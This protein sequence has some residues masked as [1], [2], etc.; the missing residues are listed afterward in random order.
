M[1]DADQVAE[2]HF[3]NVLKV[4]DQVKISAVQN[5]GPLSETASDE[6]KRDHEIHKAVL[7]ALQAVQEADITANE[8]K[9]VEVMMNR[10]K[11]LALDEPGTFSF[12]AAWQMVLEAM[13]RS[14]GPDYHDLS[15]ASQFSIPNPTLKIL[16][17]SANFEDAEF[18]ESLDAKW[19]VFVV[20]SEAKDFQVFPPF[21]KGKPS[22]E[23]GLEN[24]H[25]LVSCGLL[26]LHSFAV[27][28]LPR[29]RIFLRTKQVLKVLSE[30]PL[31]TAINIPETDD[32]VFEPARNDYK[33]VRNVL[34][35]IKV[36]D[37]ASVCEKYPSTNSFISEYLQMKVAA[38]NKLH[39][40]IS[41]EYLWKVIVWPIWIL[42]PNRGHLQRYPRT[43]PF[44]GLPNWEILTK[45]QLELP[46]NYGEKQY[47]YLV[48]LC[49]AKEEVKETLDYV[50]PLSMQPAKLNLISSVWIDARANRVEIFADRKLLSR[51]SSPPVSGDVEL[52]LS[53][54]FGRALKLVQLTCPFITDQFPEVKSTEVTLADQKYVLELQNLFKYELGENFSFNRICQKLTDCV[55]FDKAVDEL[56]NMSLREALEFTLRPLHRLVGAM[57]DH[58][59]AF[60]FP[61]PDTYA[62]NTNLLDIQ[63]PPIHIVFDDVKTRQH[64]E[65]YFEIVNFIFETNH[66]WTHT[67]LKIAENVIADDVVTVYVTPI[68]LSLIRAKQVM[69]GLWN[70]Y[71][72]RAMDLPDLKQSTASR[73][74]VQ[75]VTALHR[76][77]N[78]LKE[79]DEI[80]S[81]Q[82]VKRWLLA[83]WF[84]GNDLALRT[85]LSFP[86][87]WG[88]VVN[89]I[90]AVLK[91]GDMTLRHR[92]AS[93]RLQIP[94][95]DCVSAEGDWKI[96]N[97]AAGDDLM[98]PYIAIQHSLNIQ[99]DQKS[100]VQDAETKTL[101]QLEKRATISLSPENLYLS[102]VENQSFMGVP[103]TSILPTQTA[104]SQGTSSSTTQSSASGSAISS[105][106]GRETGE[107]VDPSAHANN[108]ASLQEQK[109]L[110]EAVNLDRKN[111]QERISSLTNLAQQQT[112]NT[113]NSRQSTLQQQRFSPDVNIRSRPSN[114]I[115]DENA[116]LKTRNFFYVVL[117]VLAV[118]GVAVGIFFYLRNQRLAQNNNIN[119][120]QTYENNQPQFYNPPFQAQQQMPR[121]A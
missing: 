70:C 11:D 61:L 14:S 20:L 45:T 79:H 80:A 49:D 56:P 50:N 72:F 118:G 64:R 12:V 69:Q 22:E 102:I 84:S 30:C 119:Y 95:P 52:H 46:E 96:D 5:L 2:E 87:A 99:I 32:T 101:V 21:F 13:W 76:T 63:N 75:F 28:Y 105:H 85:P 7:F 55:Q 51:L 91:P 23:K 68:T 108:S 33:F 42:L 58:W 41:L 71:S 8:T 59:E 6:K 98:W 37:N 117:A 29:S 74:N 104:A 39:E 86:Q 103:I 3:I 110:M 81:Y 107:S 9:Y 115:T 60:Y 36:P 27:Y 35:L 73:E 93:P 47:P 90:W 100:S 121:S 116:T 111:T 77:L 57:L 25:S 114:A 4:L 43:L 17:A 65:N 40:P 67:Y 112:T 26:P 83:K 97:L 48:I 53:E 16:P 18:V 120:Q 54:Q 19:A 31:L 44:E 92:L 15:A 24:G 34:Q 78:E 109:R 66:A 62:R 1:P 38:D 106:L 88:L 94:S 82:S 113:Q 10:Y 89:T